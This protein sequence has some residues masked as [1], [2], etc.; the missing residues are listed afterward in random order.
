MGQTRHVFARDLLAALGAPGT[1]ENAV[2]LIAQMQAEGGAA[3]FNP[4]NCTVKAPGSTDY[5]AVPVQNYTTWEQGVDVTAGMLKQ[6]NMKALHGALMIGS[7]AATYWAA[8]PGKWGTSPPAGY[9]RP[10]WL[11]DVRKHWFDR[12]MRTIAGS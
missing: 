3:K 9:T 7:N 12:S 11:A 5:N 10:Q 1:L 8:L 6:P 4:L 2:A